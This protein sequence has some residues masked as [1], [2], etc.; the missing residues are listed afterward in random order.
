MSASFT[1]LSLTNTANQLSLGAGSITTINCPTPLSNRNITIPDPGV[2]SSRFILQDSA[3]LQTINSG[4][5]VGGSFKIS[6]T[7]ISVPV[8]TRT[9][10]IPD[11]Y[12]STFFLLCT[13]VSLNNTVTRPAIQSFD[14]NPKNQWEIRAISQVDEHDDDGFL[15]LRAGGGTNPTDAV[16]IDLSGM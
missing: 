13:I 3:G 5:S 2:T 6:S 11:P 16:Y 10:T 8:A 12:I 15:R 7:T 1:Y 9:I 14:S 4:L